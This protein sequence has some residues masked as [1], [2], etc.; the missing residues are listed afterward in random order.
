MAQCQA[1]TRAG[2]PC[3]ANAILGG[4]VCN[5]HGGNLPQ[6]KRAAQRRLALQEGLAEAAR[7]GPPP[8]EEDPRHPVEHLLASLRW[9]AVL[10][11]ALAHAVAETDA[12]PRTALYKEW[13]S[14]RDRHVRIAKACADAGIEERRVQ[15]EEHQAELFSRALRGILRDC[16]VDV[17]DPDV[18]R[19]V[20]KHMMA[21]TTRDAA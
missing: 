8:P 12:N 11:E 18:G 17:T 13:A 16:G 21:L 6:V 5:K 15:I 1:N 19:S 14:E 9:S 7:K 3:R 10:V 2:R 4:T 20:R